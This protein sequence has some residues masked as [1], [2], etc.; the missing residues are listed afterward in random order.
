MRPF[1]GIRVVDA[2]H[3]LAGPFAAYQLAILGADVVKVERL[4]HDPDQ[5]R[6]Q[7]A[8]PDLNRANMGAFYLAQ[9]S[10]KRSI[11]LDIKHAAAQEIVRRLAAKAD[12]FLENYRPGAFEALGLGYDDLAA[13]NAQLIYCSM[14]AFGQ[15]GPRGH[16]TGYDNIIQAASGLMAMTGTPEVNP[17]KL[18]AP[19]VDYATGLV[20]AFAVSSAL[21][22]R[23]RTGKGQHI[24]VSMLDTALL[25]ASSHLTS[26]TAS[27]RAP[28]PNGNAYHFAT[29]GGYATRDGYVMLSAS[30]L[31][32][33]KKLW[34]LLGR[35]DMVKSSSAERI[36]DR[37]REEALLIG[38]FRTRSSQEW[39]EL[40]VPARIPVSRVRTLP[41]ALA[42][43]QIASRKLLHRLPAVPGTDRPYDVP[44]SAFKLAHGGPSIE[45]PPPALGAD[46]DAVLHEI[47]FSDEEI[48]ALR[49]AG[50]IGPA[51]S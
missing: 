6:T 35:P 39:E 51:I 8:D 3:V 43:P 49:A 33:Q 15:D 41:E 18:G 14:S 16:Q 46:T 13:L 26:Y 21:F 11:A 9:G 36:A 37:D 42:D 29:M 10:N 7:G 38:I 48:A 1:E 34:E 2:T 45:T 22:Q 50:T 12:V 44:M 24:D 17:V 40:L 25:M 5:V 20:G 4:A 19:I 31:R 23:T 30:N 28:K 47:G 32:Q 27:G